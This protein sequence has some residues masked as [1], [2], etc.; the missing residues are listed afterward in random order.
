MRDGFRNA[1]GSAGDHWNAKRERFALRHAKRFVQG[2]L[3][4]QG[5]AP[6][7]GGSVGHEAGKI[8]VLA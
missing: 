8:N 4:D 7:Q 6:V 1:T 3:H 2:G 5:C